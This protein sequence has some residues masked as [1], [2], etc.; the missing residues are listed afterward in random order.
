MGFSVCSSTS[1]KG[2]GDASPLTARLCDF[3]LVFVARSIDIDSNEVHDETFTAA[4]SFLLYVMTSAVS[5]LNL[6]N[7]KNNAR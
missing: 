7:A 1:D 2:G 6:V 5:A 4:R 3:D